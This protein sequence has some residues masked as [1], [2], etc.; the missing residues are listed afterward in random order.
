MMMF[1]F[2]S[3]CHCRFPLTKRIPLD[4][5]I[6]TAL[7]GASNRDITLHVKSATSFKTGSF[8]ID[9]FIVIGEEGEK[10]EAGVVVLWI[11][12]PDEVTGS[13]PVQAESISTNITKSI[14][15]TNFLTL[16]LRLL[17]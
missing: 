14:K 5:E 10:K 1:D 12:S 17:V 11:L 2:N 6:F 8:E 13:S 16:Y 4:K 9:K 3:P 7:F 15:D